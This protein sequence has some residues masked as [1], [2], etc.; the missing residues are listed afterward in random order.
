MLL[1]FAFFG[2]PILS[3]LGLSGS[4]LS[5]AGGVILFISSVSA[6]R[7]SPGTA[8]YGAAKAGVESLARSLAVEWGPKVRVVGVA[9]GMVRVARGLD[10][11]GR[12]L[13][14]TRFWL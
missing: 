10:V 13:R 12:M 14:S 2:R 11:A 6:T 3:V 9:G 4:S 1:V 7:P 5:I 8:A